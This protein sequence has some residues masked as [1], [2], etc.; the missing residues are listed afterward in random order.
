MANAG[1]GFRQNDVTRFQRDTFGDVDRCFNDRKHLHVVLL[2]AR[3]N[4]LADQS[5]AAQSRNQLSDESHRASVV[6]TLP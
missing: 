3:E 5:L 6:R 1:R 2:A 4:N